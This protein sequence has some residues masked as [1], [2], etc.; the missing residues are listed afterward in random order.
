[1]PVVYGV[2]RAVEIASGLAL[3]WAILGC[4]LMRTLYPVPLALVLFAGALL[5]ASAVYVPL[6]IGRRAVTR[7]WALNA[8]K[9]LVV[10]R[11]VLM[12][13]V[14]AA[15]APAPATLGLLAATLVASIGSQVLLRERY[16]QQATL[17]A[18]GRSRQASGGGSVAGQGAVA[19]GA[20]PTD[21]LIA[22]G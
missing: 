5:L 2:V 16:E 20:V 19:T 4:L 3:C 1:V 7:R 17:S 15:Y 18:F 13:A 22:D 6:W 10:E 9:Y 21:K 12:S 14:I 8:H 11:L